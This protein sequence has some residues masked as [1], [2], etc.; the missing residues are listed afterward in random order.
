MSKITKELTVADGRTDH[1][2]RKAPLLKGWF[3]L[4]LD[5]GVLIGIH[6]LEK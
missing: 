5:D 6:V 2:F 4:R 1:N 3:E